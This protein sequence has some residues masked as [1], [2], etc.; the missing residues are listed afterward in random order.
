MA[1]TEYRKASS[2]ALHLVCAV[3][4]AGSVG[5][6][7]KGLAGSLTPDF[8]GVWDVTYD[9]SMRVEVELAPD[10]VVHE[11]L[12]EQ[13]GELALHDASVG[14]EL[15]IDCARHD[16][17]CPVEVWPRELALQGAPGELDSDG[18]Q[19]VHSIV[20]KAGSGRCAA[21]AGSLVTGEVMTVAVASAVRPEAVALTSGRVR[22]VLDGACFA[23]EAALPT[24]SRVVLTAG[25]TAAK[26]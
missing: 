24:G 9:D 16:L 8:S 12:S 18:V 21:Q 22:V 13:G 10:E 1:L 7:E 26:R 4:L 15:S 17:V 19:L 25:Y 14:S 3:A 6:C 5:A 2:C 20:G 23:P 11:S